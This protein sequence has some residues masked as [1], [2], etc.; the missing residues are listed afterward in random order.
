MLKG[1][2]VG[3]GGIH[4]GR[5]KVEKTSIFFIRTS[6][7]ARDDAKNSIFSLVRFF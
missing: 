3:G 1:D 5:K 7:F 4:S 2:D 6:L